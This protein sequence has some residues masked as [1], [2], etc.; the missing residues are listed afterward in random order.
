MI[1]D[2]KPT[3]TFWRRSTMDKRSAVVESITNF[4]CLVTRVW[5]L[6]ILLWEGKD[7]ICHHVHQKKRERSRRAISPCQ[8]IF[9]SCL[10]K[11]DHKT[12]SKIW[13]RVIRKVFNAL[14]EYQKFALET[15]NWK[16]IKNTWSIEGKILGKVLEIQANKEISFL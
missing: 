15:W 5:K 13:A 3:D 16:L 1:S 9:F 14:F 11:V 4:S 7:K 6:W 10:D 8:N 2:L 12:L